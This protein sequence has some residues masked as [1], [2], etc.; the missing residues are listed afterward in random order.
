MRL[1]PSER[2]KKCTTTTTRVLGCRLSVETS[3]PKDRRA[4]V[5][6]LAQDRVAPLSSLSRR[7]ERNERRPTTMHVQPRG[8][9][10][11]LVGASKILTA[12]LVDVNADDDDDVIAHVAAIVAR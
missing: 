4:S 1:R 12:V 5:Q 7:H 2:A 3:G 8:Y 10:G 11:H 9:G 6:Q